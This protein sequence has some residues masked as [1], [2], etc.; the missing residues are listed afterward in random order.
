MRRIKIL[1]FGALVAALAL[2]VVASK[3]RLWAQA[4]TGTAVLFNYVTNQANFDT[5]MVISNTTM[6]PLGTTPIPGTCTLNYY[7]NTNAGIAP[8]AQQS[9][10]VQPGTQLTFSLSEG[11]DH[12]ISA[13]PGFSGYL[14]AS[15]G[16]PYAQ[17]TATIT[18]AAGQKYLSLV[19]GLVLSRGSLVSTGQ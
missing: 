4:T 13:T 5:R 2:T 12:G 6:D 19:P 3:S 18:D 16:F 14:I 17:G 7:G 15:C 9:T 8:P 10:A 11:G 1:A